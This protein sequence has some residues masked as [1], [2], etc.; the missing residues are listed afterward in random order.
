MSLN[1]VFF[2]SLMLLIGVFLSY[3]GSG[4]PGA[5]VVFL[6]V[7]ASFLASRL[8]LFNFNHALYYTS[9]SCLFIIQIIILI[10]NYLFKMTYLQNTS[11]YAIFILALISPIII[12]IL[13]LKPNNSNKSSNKDIS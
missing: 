2:F 11:Q 8:N 13:L 6:A 12:L 9:L 5:L 10:N 4:N 1:R 7:V 3:L